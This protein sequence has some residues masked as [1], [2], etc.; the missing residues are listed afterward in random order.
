MN[1]Y[2]REKPKTGRGFANGPVANCPRCAAER[3]AFD[4]QALVTLI[5]KDDEPKQEVEKNTSRGETGIVYT[6]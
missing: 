5:T 2:A 3:P 4:S 6:S 1:G